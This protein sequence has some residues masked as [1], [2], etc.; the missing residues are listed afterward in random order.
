[1]NFIRQNIYSV[2]R[3]TL[4]QCCS[5]IGLTHKLCM[6]CSKRKVVST[7][8]YGLQGLEEKSIILWVCF[9]HHRF[10]FVWTLN[11]SRKIYLWV[12][13]FFSRNVCCFFWTK[14]RN[15]DATSSGVLDFIE[16]SDIRHEGVK[17]DVQNLEIIFHEQFQIFKINRLFLKHVDAKSSNLSKRKWRRNGRIR[18]ILASS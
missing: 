15:S 18:P 9:F 2:V 5:E 17:N 13:R 10:L 16:V 4:E 1:M 8:A 14:K 12:Q 11:Q 6:R 3:Q 7:R